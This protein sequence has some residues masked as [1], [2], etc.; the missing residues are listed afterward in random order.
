VPK[1]EKVPQFSDLMPRIHRCVEKGRY[2]QSIHALERLHERDIDFMDALYVLKNGYHEKPKTTFDEAFQN[3]KYAIR[4][5]TLEGLDV[6]V[7]VQFHEDL[8]II[9]TVI[10]VLRRG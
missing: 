6:R 7:V 4:G 5:K 3:W 8:M 9:L 10:E 2:R 1:P